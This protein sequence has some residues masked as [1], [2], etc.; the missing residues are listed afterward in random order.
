M[1]KRMQ[2]T[3]NKLYIFLTGCWLIFGVAFGKLVNR[4]GVARGGT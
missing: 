1:L 4:S 2:L 3:T